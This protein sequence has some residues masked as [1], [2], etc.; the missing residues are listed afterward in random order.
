MV[1]C[2]VWMTPNIYKKLLAVSK[3]QVKV[4]K[5]PQEIVLWVKI[6]RE[7]PKTM[8]ASLHTSHLVLQ[9]TWQISSNF[10]PCRSCAVL[11]GQVSPIHFRKA[12]LV[13]HLT[14]EAFPDTA[15]EIVGLVRNAL[16]LGKIQFL[17]LVWRDVCLNIQHILDLEEITSS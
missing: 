9:P 3:F 14:R 7:S 5:N 12:D 13:F 8:S 17:H 15:V 11:S 10:F 1:S 4:L 6:S 16:V 2:Y